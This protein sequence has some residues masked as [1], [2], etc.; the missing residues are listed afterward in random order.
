[1]IRPKM[2]NY[3]NK[4]PRNERGQL[5]PINNSGDEKSKFSTYNTRIQENID[6]VLKCGVEAC[7]KYPEIVLDEGDENSKGK[8]RILQLME[9]LHYLNP[10]LEPELIRKDLN[11]Q[12]MKIED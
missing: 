11:L 9:M 6:K 1:M 5:M 3:L 4:C 10:T 8:Q 2:L 12:L 7:K